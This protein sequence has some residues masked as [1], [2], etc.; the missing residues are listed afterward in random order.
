[1]M[2]VTNLQRASWAEAALIL[3]LVLAGCAPMPA[4]K[5][6]RDPTFGGSARCRVPVWP[7]PDP[8][9]PA[10]LC[11][12]YGGQQPSGGGYDANGN[13]QEGTSGGGQS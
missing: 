13:A 3:A 1:M 2:Q 9:A 12:V 10:L 11:T 6:E 8:R 7:K 4:A 5:P